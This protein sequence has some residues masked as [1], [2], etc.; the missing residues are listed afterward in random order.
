MP[1]PQAASLAVITYLS[2]AITAGSAPALLAPTGLAAASAPAF[3]FDE[4]L[5]IQRAAGGEASQQAPAIRQCAMVAMLQLL[6]AMAAHCEREKARFKQQLGSDGA[7]AG[8]GSAA[9]PAAPARSS[10]LD[11][12]Q[13]ACGFDYMQVL[14]CMHIKPLSQKCKW[15][16]WVSWPCVAWKGQGRP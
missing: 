14:T 7:G 3:V 6:A 4:E 2:H 8:A 9:G 13:D 16:P 11:T 12:N 10:E 5:G 1:D 15:W